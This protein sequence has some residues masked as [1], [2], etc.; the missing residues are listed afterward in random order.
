MPLSIL[1]CPQTI[2]WILTSRALTGA[3]CG[4]REEGTGF[5]PR[6]DKEEAKETEL[7]INIILLIGRNVKEI[8]ETFQS[9]LAF[10]RSSL[11][12]L[13]LLARG[14]RPQGPFWVGRLPE[15]MG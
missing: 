1:T 8:Y 12:G 2:S 4:R 15:A 5:R 14:V 11:N 13:S 3:V 10:V 9:F 6:P 7:V